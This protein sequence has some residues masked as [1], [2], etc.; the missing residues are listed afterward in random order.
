MKSVKYCFKESN[1]WYLCEEAIRLFE[2][3]HKSGNDKD[4][5]AFM[6]HKEHCLDEYEYQQ[7]KQDESDLRTSL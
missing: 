7:Q 3:A 1:T 5:E 4:L 6:D 2:I